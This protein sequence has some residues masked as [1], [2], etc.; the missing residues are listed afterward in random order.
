[1]GNGKKH[2]AVLE[3]LLLQ[4]TLPEMCT[5]IRQQLKYDGLKIELNEFMHAIESKLVSF[6]QIYRSLG[7]TKPR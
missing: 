2:G 3:T 6:E 5:E 1:M 7:A 4:G